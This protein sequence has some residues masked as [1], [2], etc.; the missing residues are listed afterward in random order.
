VTGYSSAD[1]E[2]LSFIPGML[3][4]VLSSVLY[5]NLVCPCCYDAWPENGN[6]KR[7]TAKHFGVNAITRTITVRRPSS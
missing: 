1:I 4:P 2:Q 6:V 3:W 7:D 5:S